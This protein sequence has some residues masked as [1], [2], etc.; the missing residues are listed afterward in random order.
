M[1]APTTPFLKCLRQMYKHRR[2]QCYKQDNQ[3]SNME[4]DGAQYNLDGFY[5]WHVDND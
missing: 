3:F 4:F 5:D 1:L 2:K